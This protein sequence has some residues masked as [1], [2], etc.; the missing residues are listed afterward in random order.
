[1]KQI[2]MVALATTLVTAA[3]A[4]DSKNPLSCCIPVQTS[5][6][7]DAHAPIGVMGD[8]V[9][10]QGE[11]MFSY[12]YMF[13]A[14]DGHRDGNNS[15]TSSEVYDRGYTGAGTSM[16]MQMHMLGI[17]YAPTDKLT[18]MSMFN[19]VRK[20]MDMD[21]A[22]MMMGGMHSMHSMSHSGSH[23]SEG[24]GDT[25]LTALYSL[26]SDN[27]QSLH[28]TLGLVL[29]TADVD[30]KQDGMYLPYGMQLGGGTWDG[31]L[32]LTYQQH[33]ETFS[34]GVQASTRTVLEE[35]NES[36]FAYGDSYSLTSWIATPVTESL[37]L[38]ARLNYSYQEDIQGHYNG[39]HHHSAPQHFQENYGG[40]VLEAGLGAN[41]IFQEG[42]F[43]G[44]RLAVEALI[45][46]YQEANGI[47]MNR[48]FSVMLGWQK[49]F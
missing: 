20:D 45:P 14:M 21:M 17:M 5:A 28:L 26:Y 15:L 9:H 37:S 18:L 16:D 11:W 13:M 44:H 38:S 42:S 19:Y 46:I 43:K 3:H 48:E 4:Q 27:T 31:I 12:R 34:W 2:A 8:H 29:P 36:G 35:D 40:H 49:A 1:M 30:E 6:R 47:G 10:K 23:S 32:G 41:F 22:P 33:L 7:P 39:M 25:S 24:L